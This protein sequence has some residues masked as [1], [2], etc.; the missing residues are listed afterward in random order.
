MISV[1]LT[2]TETEVTIKS[3]VGR[4]Q[5]IEFQLAGYDRTERRF[6]TY[7]LLIAEQAVIELI[8]VQLLNQKEGSQ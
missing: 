8:V 7:K 3:L 1:I 5:S 4:S 6:P 2:E